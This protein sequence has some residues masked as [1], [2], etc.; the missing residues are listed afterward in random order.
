MR[1]SIGK[2]IIN[3]DEIFIYENNEENLMSIIIGTE[4]INLDEIFNYENNYKYDREG[5]DYIT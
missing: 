2:E 1:I 5:E 4:I 3:L